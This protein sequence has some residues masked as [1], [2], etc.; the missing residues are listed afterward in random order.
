MANSTDHENS[1]FEKAC[2]KALRRDGSRV[3]QARVAV[4]EALAGAASPQS[5]KDVHGAVAELHPDAAI[6]LVSV[7]RTLE[8]LEGLDM[9]HQVAPGGHYLPCQHTQC[10][11][12]MHILIHCRRCEKLDELDVPAQAISPLVS[13]LRRTRDFK[14]SG[15]IF[16]IDGICG[17]CH[18]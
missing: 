16:Q 18:V 1:T 4:I 17:D 6:D 15:H 12:G 2:L 10:N 3:T 8:K 14:L 7:Y 13:F 11:E 5:P 9:V